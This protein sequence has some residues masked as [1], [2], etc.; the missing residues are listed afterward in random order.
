MIRVVIL[1]VP[2]MNLDK[3]ERSPVGI[4]VMHSQGKE[5]QLQY[6]WEVQSV[7]NLPLSTFMCLFSCSYSIL[8][9]L[10]WLSHG[11]IYF[12]KKNWWCWS[13]ISVPHLLRQ[14]LYHLSHTSNSRR[15]FCGLH[16]LWIGE[17]RATEVIH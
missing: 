12:R 13:F 1:P 10:V 4:L 16:F 15:N 9:K 8:A 5:C 14:V 3:A 11:L 2:W 7:E 17:L 6:W